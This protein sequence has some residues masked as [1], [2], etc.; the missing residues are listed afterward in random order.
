MVQFILFLSL[1]AFEGL[2]ARSNRAPQGQYTQ[3][4][5]YSLPYDDRVN[6]LINKLSSGN[7]YLSEIYSNFIQHERLKESSSKVAEKPNQTRR[8]QT[9]SGFPRKNAYPKHKGKKPRTGNKKSYPKI[10]KT[11]DKN[12]GTSTF[13]QQLL[14]AVNAERK[15][16]NLKAFVLNEKLNAA[17]AMQSKYQAA[18]N[19]CS[20]TGEGGSDPSDRCK[21][22]GYGL[23]G[24]NVALG[25]TSV[26]QVMDSWM[27]SQGHRDNI[28]NPKYK[29]FGAARVGNAWTQNFGFGANPYSPSQD[30]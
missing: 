12:K 22:N 5:R 28:L 21:A 16:L 19:I 15:K 26:A 9:K 10:T 14:A 3:S 25:Q 27:H 2:A 23:C 8:K 30:Y 18:K 29:E 11:F 6:E 7:P 13:A 24:E 20:H 4:H 1:F 17:A